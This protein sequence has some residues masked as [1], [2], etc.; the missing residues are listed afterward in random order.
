MIDWNV[1]T[2]GCGQQ[3]DWWLYDECAAC[4]AG[5]KP[6]MSPAQ[7]TKH[8]KPL[9]T[10]V[11]EQARPSHVQQTSVSVVEFLH[12]VTHGLNNV[13]VSWNV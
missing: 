5:A 4:P 3:A 2:A 10:L 6:G 11:E 7:T 1:I 8:L 12:T 9:T 13:S